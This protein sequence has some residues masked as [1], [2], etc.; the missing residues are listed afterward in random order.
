MGSRWVS[1]R[2]AGVCNLD[3][4]EM[5][6]A[7]A[8]FP[9]GFPTSDC[10]GSPLWHLPCSGEDKNSQKVPHLEGKTHTEGFAEG[11]TK[12]LIKRRAEGESIN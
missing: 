8:G 7:A 6:D 10:P 4:V 1:N 9:T 5:G 12:G 3:K 11:E 2:L